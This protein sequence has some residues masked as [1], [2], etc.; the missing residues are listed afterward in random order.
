MRKAQQIDAPGVGQ[1]GQRVPDPL[2]FRELMGQFATGVCIIAVPAEQG[3]GTGPSGRSDPGAAGM[4]VNSLVSVS[5]EPM[6]IAWGIQNSSSQ[7]AAFTEAP[8]FTVSILAEDQHQLARRYAARGNSERDLGD[9]A[10]SDS[11]LPVIADAVGYLEC[12][13]WSLYE[14]GDHTMIFGQVTGIASAAMKRPLGF[15]AGEFC[16]IAR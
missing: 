16:R 6:L 3:G 11:G 12:R 2:A 7:F 1:T 14:A 9:F 8:D 4:T 13:R 10:F 15:H 5:L